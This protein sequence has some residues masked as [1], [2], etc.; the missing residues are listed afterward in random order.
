MAKFELLC[1][2]S[3]VAVIKIGKSIYYVD[4]ID[5][6]NILIY[7]HKFSKQNIIIPE[8]W[9]PEV[10]RGEATLSV[11]KV[12]MVAFENGFNAGHSI[13]AQRHFKRFSEKLI[14]LILRPATAQRFMSLFWVELRPFAVV[15]NMIGT[16]VNNVDLCN[17]SATAARTTLD[18]YVAR[19]ECEDNVHSD[20]AY[21]IAS[22]LPPVV[23]DPIVELLELLDISTTEVPH[24]MQNI[25]HIV[26][27]RS[28]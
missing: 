13:K 26:A 23:F 6:H 15:E 28:R 20:K 5:Y 2:K 8:F 22:T 24:L 9:L 14:Q 12:A 27:L 18:R 7:D 16:L 4:L 21:A 1:S 11:L 17:K 25:D 19:A 10:T 3:K